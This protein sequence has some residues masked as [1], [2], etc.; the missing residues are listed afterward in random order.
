MKTSKKKKSSK[1]GESDNIA[2]PK[3]AKKIGR[4]TIYTEELGIR[5][6]E[7]VAC[8]P[9]SLK[10]LCKENDWM[11]DD[12]TV[13]DWVA[14]HPAFA[15]AY[16]RAKKKQCD[17]HAD[18]TI[19]IIDDSITEILKPENKQ[20]ASALAQVARNRVEARQWYIGKL[21]PRKYSERKYVDQKIDAKVENLTEDQLKE[22]TKSLFSRV[23]E[24]VKDIKGAV[25]EAGK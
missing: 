9:V 24:R 21:S 15:S 14:R 13:F 10:K 16:A 4:E 19:H 1:K 8:N 11:P 25:K 3:V 17:A 2:L 7:L 5:I 6:C 18:E 20:I 12:S 22:K 23:A